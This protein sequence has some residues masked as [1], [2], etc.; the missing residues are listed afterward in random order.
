VTRAIFEEIKACRF[1][2]IVGVAGTIIAFR[3]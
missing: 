1:D 3:I 2:R